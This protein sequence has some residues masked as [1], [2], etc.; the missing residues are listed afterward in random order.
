[1]ALVS[2]MPVLDR[3][4]VELG[5][6]ETMERRA[7]IEEIVPVQPTPVHERVQPGPV[8]EEKIY[9]AVGKEVKEYKSTV[10]WASRNAGGKKLCIL[11]VH[12]PA[13]MIP[14]PMG[15]KF[16]ASRLKPGAV[17]AYRQKEREKLQKILDEYVVICAKERV[18]AEKLVIEMDDIETGIIEL[19]TQHGITELV[20]GAAA[21][22]HFSRKMKEP[23]SKKAI[24]VAREAHLSCHISFV[25]KGALVCTR[26]ASFDGT[27]V[28]VTPPS[29]IPS[30]SC[31]TGPSPPLNLKSVSLGPAVA[32]SRLTNPV[33]NSLTH[34]KSANAPTRGLEVN[35][36]PSPEERRVTTMLQSLLSVAGS[37]DLWEGI[38]KGSTSQGS[39]GSAWST[40][41]GVGTSNSNSIERDADSEE[42][43]VLPPLNESEEDSC[44]L[45]P[46]HELEGQQTNDHQVYEQLEKAMAEAHISRQ[47]ALEEL[48]RRQKAEK[49]AI[50]ATLR[51]REYEGL[52]AKELKQRKEMEE[53]LAREMP[54]LNT[55][56][57]QQEEVFEE[58]QRAR[59][60]QLELE[61][62]VAR[63]DQTARE[64]EEKYSEAQQLLAT[65]KRERDEMQRERD[66]AIRGAEELHRKNEEASASS[67]RP[68]DFSEC[69]F[70]E[71]EEATRTFD[72]SL[73]IGEGGYGK[74]YKGV[75][76]HTPVAI[77]VLHPES[78]Q[79]RPEF[80]QEVD[81]LS[82]VRHPNLVILM[83]TCPE[84]WSLIYEYLPNG[85]LED[86]LLCKDN[87]PPLSWQIRTRI[88]AEVCSA[89]IFLHSSRPQGIVHG[90]VKPAN[91]LLDAN[92]ISKLSDF[93]ICRLIPQKNT[94]STLCWRTDPKGTFAYMDPEFQS[95]GVLTPK[96]DVYSFGVILLRLLTGLPALGIVKEVQ[97]ALDEGTLHTILDELAGDW[98]FVQ[99]KQL[100]YLGVR[101]CEMTRKS[102]PDLESE[103]WRVLEPMIASSGTPL[104]FQLLPK[105]NSRTPSHFIC[106]I[107]LEIMQDPHVAAD[108]FTYE[109]EALRGWLENGHD[110]S[111]MTNIRLAHNELIPNRALKSAI[112][113]W[114]QKR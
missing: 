39:A 100:A 28:W 44:F 90:D 3:Q 22:K 83:G 5:V 51:A 112:Q 25:C 17:R 14:M 62:Q 2:S 96:S 48:V 46:L 10:V 84:A 79:G 70:L 55:I 1:M 8:R 43:S 37:S 114:L 102:R 104:S 53:L 15:A 76:R 106:P 94:S 69:S 103:V 64:M 31:S 105:D 19:V 78:L 42:G 27:G 41:E 113:E 74:V 110:T 59:E 9:V 85:S 38:P 107:F 33:L 12:Q 68:H 4:R 40:S 77:K 89:L 92:F 67:C 61:V 35:G 11:H 16:P 72:P 24:F 87:T 6:V 66:E 93:G 88:A 32:V 30:P 80:H 45:S 23:R 81:V 98:P 86:R 52:Y 75:L 21:D 111:P 49:D 34:S 73:K 26:E 82:R 20:M 65:L 71:I 95:T 58:L 99:A 97:Q 13:Q 47:E 57:Q 108:G 91:I 29:P 50:R 109:A 63:A 60:Q 56:K 54:Q 18:R 101:C 36:T 7:E